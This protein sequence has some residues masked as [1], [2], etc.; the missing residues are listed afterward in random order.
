L[1]G[2]VGE[3]G[4]VAALFSLGI[5]MGSTFGPVLGGF[6]G[7]SLT[8]QSAF[9]TPIAFIASVLLILVTR[10]V[11]SRRPAEAEAGSD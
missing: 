8:L 2:V 11:R 6:V 7:E 5:S 9:I 3:K 4:K 10:D 1:S